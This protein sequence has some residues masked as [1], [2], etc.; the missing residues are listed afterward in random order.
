MKDEESNQGPRIACAGCGKSPVPLA[1]PPVCEECK[2]V[3][4]D[5]FNEDEEVKE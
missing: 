2:Q 5:A 3:W 1:S 4:L